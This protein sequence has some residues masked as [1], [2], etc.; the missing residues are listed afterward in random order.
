LKTSDNTRR[1]M[2]Q[3][4]RKEILANWTWEIRI[5]SLLKKLEALR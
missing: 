2:G 3:E 4:A 1:K 5:P